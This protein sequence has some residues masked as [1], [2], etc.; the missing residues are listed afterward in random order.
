MCCVCD[1]NGI[2]FK[3]LRNP[4]S[5]DEK[6]NVILRGM[7]PAFRT[8]LAG[9]TTMHSV[10]DLRRVSSR[11]EMIKG[12]GSD[13]H[14]VSE[15]DGTAELDQ[16]SSRYRKRDDHWCL[17]CQ[18]CEGRVHQV[19][20]RQ[21]IRCWGCGALGVKK[22]QCMKCEDRR[23]NRHTEPSRCDELHVLHAKD[24]YWDH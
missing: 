3:G 23:L 21:E 16:I 6:I 20:K 18:D 22:N 5:E 19:P 12:L 24:L 13:I 9:V 8:T 7:K 1:E 11:V 15:K 17:R 4:P 14:A 2:A 10:E